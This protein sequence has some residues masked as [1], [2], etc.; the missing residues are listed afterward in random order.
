[1][2]VWLKNLGFHP[3]YHVQGRKQVKKIS[4]KFFDDKFH[5]FSFTMNERKLFS[6][7]PLPHYFFIIELSFFDG[8]LF[9]T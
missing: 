4:I 6:T 3:F 8:N 1:M 9:V 2:N 7:F 5:K